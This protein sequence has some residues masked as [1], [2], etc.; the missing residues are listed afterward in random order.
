MPVSIDKSTD[1]KKLLDDLLNEYNEFV[2]EELIKPHRK[3]KKLNPDSVNTVRFTTYLDGD[4]VIVHD[5]F[6]KVGQKGSFV[7]NGGAGGIFVHVDP[8]TGRFDTNG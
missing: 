4:N 7:D 6:M 2:V 5:T 1:F 8:L 3:I